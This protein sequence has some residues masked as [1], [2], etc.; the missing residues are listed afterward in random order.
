MDSFQI[1]YTAQSHGQ[2][3][4]LDSTWTVSKFPIRILFRSSQPKL[5]RGP[6][7]SWQAWG[8]EENL[9]SIKVSGSFLESDVDPDP[10]SR[11]LL[12]GGEV[13]S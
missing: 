11:S 12:G 5:Y 10:L 13:G 3:N 9:M 4:F 2:L 6:R 1:S 8:E 7:N